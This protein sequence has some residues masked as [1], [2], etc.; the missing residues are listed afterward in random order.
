MLLTLL[1]V[2]LPTAALAQHQVRY[3]TGVQAPPNTLANVT[4]TAGFGS[5]FSVD[6]ICPTCSPVVGPDQVSPVEISLTG[7]SL[8]CTDSSFCTFTNG[9]ATVKGLGGGVIFRDTVS[10]DIGGNITIGSD[11]A[12]I[13]ADLTPNPLFNAGGGTENFGFTFTDDTATGGTGSLI[14]DNVVPEP[15]TLWQL[16][17]GLIGLGG[18][19]IRKLKT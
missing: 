15:G 7:A 4:F 13:M 16:A 10:M 1:T 17:T 9:T 3:N 14:A 11:S 8:T 12:V 5:P 6:V 19:A 18:I 2:A